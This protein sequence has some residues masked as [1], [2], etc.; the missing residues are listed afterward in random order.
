MSRKLQYSLGAA[1]SLVFLYIAFRGTDLHQLARSIEGADYVW[2]FISLA[3]LFLSHLVRAY[4]WRFLL[5]PV[6]ESIGLRNLFSGVMIGYLMNNVLP[7]AGEIARPYALSRLEAIS[8]SSAFGTVVM[9]RILDVGMFLLLVAVLPLVYS[10][11]LLGTFPWLVT[12]GIITSVVIVLTFA[13]VA[14]LLLRPAFTSR[15]L[16]GLS[17][18]LP[19]RISERLENLVR[20]FLE[21]FRTLTRPRHLLAI[22]GLSFGVWF[23][24]AEMTYTAFF[25]FHLQQ[26]LDFSSAIV[27]LTVASVGVAIPT[28][29][30]TGSY[31]VLV[32]QALTRLFGVDGPTALS[33]ATLTH[34]FSFIAVSIVGAYYL[35][36]DHVTFTDAIR[37]TGKD[38]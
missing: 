13:A 36:R 33:Y 26:R 7:R 38:R 2:L 18:V 14:T 11:P 27:V 30:G 10:G 21:G 8:A 4:R 34:A 19:R 22:T 12:S 23:L 35:S 29:G 1:L 25:A 28:P 15:I 6:K 17:H 9:E 31:H 3:C 5:D 37:L 16:G 20:A 24:Y 32:S